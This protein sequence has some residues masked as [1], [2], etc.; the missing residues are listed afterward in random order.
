MLQELIGQVVE[1]DLLLPMMVG[2]VVAYLWLRG[3][4]WS[5]RRVKAAMQP[6]VTIQKTSRT[7]LQ[8]VWSSFI[9]CLTLGL[10]LAIPIVI[11]I[12]YM[13]NR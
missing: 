13:I 2:F 11:A 10:L 12:L 6:Q 4:S 1:E 5:Q 3:L 8:V 9:G 7:P